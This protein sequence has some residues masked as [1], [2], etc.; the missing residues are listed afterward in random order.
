MASDL[1]KYLCT[2]AAFACVVGV[3]AHAQTAVPHSGDADKA[4]AGKGRRQRSVRTNYKRRRADQFAKVAL[5]RQTDQKATTSGEPAHSSLRIVKGGKD[6]LVAA[7]APAPKPAKPDVAAM[8]P[9]EEIFV[10]ALTGG[11][12]GTPVAVATP[13]ASAFSW[14]PIAAGLFGA[15]VLAE[16]ASA[17]RDEH[18]STSDLPGATLPG[19]PVVPGTPPAPTPPAPPSPTAPDSSGTT[20]HVPPVPP[21]PPVV[22]ASPDTTHSTGTPPI[23]NPYTPTGSD[24]TGV[25][26]P[27]PTTTTTTPEPGTLLLMGT[28]LGLLGIAAKR[29]KMA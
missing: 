10:E 29:K 28:G 2:V 1:R 23:V 4:T 16:F 24:S 14:R 19:V 26:Q 13:G 12:P 27:T 21:L 20:P 11:L 7:A 5:R 22:P 8:V 17:K 18:G 3:P 6:R 15:A 9:T 25:D